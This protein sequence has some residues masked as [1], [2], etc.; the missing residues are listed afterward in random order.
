LQLAASHTP[1]RALAPR[2]ATRA[3]LVA[4]SAALVLGASGAA[5]ASVL[6]GDDD[7]TEPTSLAPQYGLPI[8]YVPPAA[9]PAPEPPD[10][11]VDARPDGRADPP[12]R[13]R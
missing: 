10:A 4:A 2:N 9:A 5:L 1:T 11:S 7:D 13:R 6:D 12:R 8:G 3:A